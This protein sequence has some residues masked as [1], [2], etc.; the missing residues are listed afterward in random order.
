[1]KKIRSKWA[2]LLPFVLLLSSCNDEFLQRYPLD[3]ISNETFWNSETDLQAYNNNL[4]FMASDDGAVPIMLGNSA[5][6]HSPLYLDF[7]SD[8]LAG[9][10]RTASHQQYLLLRGQRHQVPVSASGQLFGYRGWNFLRAINIGL[11]N[12]QRAS[13]PAA[14]INRYAGEA[15]LF[16]GWFYADKVS[17]F[18][19]VAWVDKEL[20]VDSPE[21][22]ADRSPR[23]EVMQH[24]L[25]DL[26]FA[27]E[28]LPNSW[29]NGQNPGRMNRWMALLVKSRIC[30]FEGTWRKYHGGTNPEMWLQEAAKA[31]QE[32]IDNGPYRLHST[33]NPAR[34]YNHIH[35]LIDLTNN[36][37]VIYWRKYA[38]GVSQ[39]RTQGYHNR[40]LGGATRDAVE[41]YLCTDGLPISLSPLYAGD[42]KIEDVFVNRDPRLRQTVLHPADA[43]AYELQTNVNFPYPVF[44]GQGNNE[45]QL[46]ETGYHVIKHFNRA[47]DLLDQNGYMPAI[48]ARYGEVLLNY[49]EAKAE[50][51]TL[52][53]EDLDKTI[54]RLRTRVGMPHLN[55][56]Q[57]PVDPRYANEGISPLLV[58]IRRE[59]RIELFGEGFRYDDLRRWKQGKKLEKPTWGIRWDEAARARFPQATVTFANDPTRGNIPYLNAYKGSI[60][61]NTIFDENKHYLWPIPL[62]VIAANTNIRQNPG[63]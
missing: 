37:E 47:M 50:L 25:A 22:F 3:R 44:P 55:L 30:L 24:V 35:R 52:T 43:M 27:T 10:F 36:P 19:D 54:N 40:A 8:N 29:G 45:I 60:I 23:E 9:T 41:D 57:V 59:R 33:G 58:E 14:V 13:L 31:A 62:D 15:R 12:Y 63:W 28:N 26:N 38:P 4:Y 20:N 53:Q 49:A 48:V 1:M 46:T 11:A 7:W 61:E 6:L 16:R 42:A 56:S 18:G 32:V 2:I 51:S 21:L 34:D 5:I 39:N 17:K